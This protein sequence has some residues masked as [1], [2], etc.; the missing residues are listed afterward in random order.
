[1]TA[2]KVVFMMSFYME[3]NRALEKMRDGQFALGIQLR[4]R[5]PLIAELMGY[6]G[7]DFLYIETEHFA[8][9]DESVENL[10]RAAQVSGIT[11]W[12]RLTDTD[13]ENIGHM[14]D[15]GVQGV[16]VPHLET[17]EEGRRLVNAVKY[18]P[19]GHRGSG[20]QS[21][22]ACFGCMDG[23][24]YL[25]ASNRNCSAIGMIESVKAVE[26]LEAILDTGV[27]MIRVGRSDLSLDMDLYGRQK[28]PCFVDT[29]RYITDTARKKGVLVG[30][31]ATDAES[32]AY[33]KSLGFNFLSVASDLDY[34]KRTLPTLLRSIQD[35]VDDH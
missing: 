10:V 25:E 23:K 34:M 12:L 6:L 32:A 17:A 19:M 5:S 26:N 8:C 22:S 15:I 21:R 18:P 27:D 30:T 4:S 28:E 2:R 9:S 11:P 1:M 24:A 13:P 3:H 20:T 7:F 33:F 14:L 29:L 31:A 35:A 16:I